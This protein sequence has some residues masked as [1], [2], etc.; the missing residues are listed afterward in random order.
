MVTTLYPQKLITPDAVITQG[1]VQWD[2][3]G[4]ILFAGAI[5]QAPFNKDTA[6]DATTL[7]AVP[8]LIDMHVHG[9]F[10]ITFGL[11]ELAIG[12][13]EYAQKVVQYGVTGFILT[14]SG[15]DSAFLTDRI[16]R[17]AALLE[18][19]YDGAQPLGIHLE[20][21]FLN[22]ARHG[23]FNPDWIHGISIMEMQRYI[24]AGQG[25]IRHVSLAPELDGSAQAAQLLERNG[26]RAAL[27]HSDADYETA[28]QALAADFTHVTH[29]FN[30]QSG[31]HHRRPG[32]VGAILTSERASAE[33]V[34]DG[35]H[36]HPAAVRILVKCLGPERVCLITDAMPGA[37][38]PDGSYQ[39]LGREV[40]V[41][42]GAARLPDGTI[43]GSTVMMN[44][45]LRNMATLVNTPLPDAARMAATNPARVLGYGDKLGR[46]IKGYTADIALLDG[47]LRVKMTIRK[48]KIIFKE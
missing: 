19:K 28:A 23:A 11:G 46:L 48:G 25:W 36:V 10:G 34:A 31:L 18:K 8:G 16:A 24:D 38:L 20:G 35:Q 41:V 27:G 9:G 33:L 12:L 29:T 45:C 1:C 30:T 40:Q 4:T 42:N 39:L 32:V 26:I 15:P 22:P 6:I 7:T 44:D 3:N 17:Y 43:A 14:I 13:E 21:P 37:G 5:T 47:D 2:E